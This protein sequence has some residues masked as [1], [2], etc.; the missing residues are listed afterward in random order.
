MEAFE[1]AV[2]PGG[3]LVVNSSLIPQ[4]SDRADVR[5]HYVPA[6]DLA[7]ELG[8]VKLANVICLGALVQATGVVP[9]QALDEALERHLPERH[10]D[11]LELNKAALQKGAAL[12]GD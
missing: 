8:S 7:N 4:R 1:P 6:T 9:L 5:V 10:R 12:A 3:V 11:L 2:K